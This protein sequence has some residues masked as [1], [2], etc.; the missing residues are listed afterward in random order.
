MAEAIPIQAGFGTYGGRAGL[1]H[2][3][4][5]AGHAIAIVRSSIALVGGA[6]WHVFWRS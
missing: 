1:S 6:L 5:K 4:L 3:P 2:V